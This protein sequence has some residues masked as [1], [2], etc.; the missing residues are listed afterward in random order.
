MDGKKAFLRA[1]TL[2]LLPDSIVERQKS[3][4]PST[5]DPASYAG[6]WVMTE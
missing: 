1:A 2:E 4:Y 6:N 3:P 5:K